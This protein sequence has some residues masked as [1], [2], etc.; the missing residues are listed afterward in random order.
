MKAE[1][2]L[3]PILTYLKRLRAHNNREWF[4]AN[5]GE[6]EAAR[7]QFEVYVAAVIKAL[8]RTEPLAGLTPKDCIF[9]INRDLRFS[10]DKT[11]YKPYMSAYIAPEGR[12]SRRLGFYLHLEPNNHSML[13]GGLHEPEP[14]Q[15]A[16]W[17]AAIDR[18]ARP[19]LKIAR[20]ASFR[21]YFKEVEGERL[22]SAPRGYAKNHPHLDL[23]RL[24]RVTITRSLTDREV[25]SP[26]VLRETL[27]TF[28][29]MK[30]F[31]AYLEALD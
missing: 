14:V 19:F 25:I 5:R 28:T 27:A 15:I 24:K 23:L 8:S 6:Y 9:R 29:A 12:K 13:G 20:A 18:D 26:R 31:L 22:K 3:E 30:P 4:V 10:K 7:A 21:R 2:H 11:P 1:I 17:R 16:A